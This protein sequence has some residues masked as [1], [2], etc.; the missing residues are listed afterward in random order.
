MSKMT[1][2]VHESAD[3][4]SLDI[5]KRLA[6]TVK[7]IMTSGKINLYYD[8]VDDVPAEIYVGENGHEIS[9]YRQGY[10]DPIIDVWISSFETEPVEELAETTYIS[11]GYPYSRAED[12][13]A[14]KTIPTYEEW[15]TT[16]EM[17]SPNY[18]DP[19]IGVYCRMFKSVDEIEK[20]IKEHTYV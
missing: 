1:I 2:K 18:Y 8:G 3:I 15:T 12:A 17:F 5:F 20:F 9:I 11:L 6:E 13:E 4:G 7:K 10:I 16:L 14:G 19:T